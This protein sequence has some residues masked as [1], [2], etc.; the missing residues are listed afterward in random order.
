MRP[1]SL[2]LGGLVGLAG[3]L[4]TP[5]PWPTEPALSLAVGTF[6]VVLAW[7]AVEQV[8]DALDR[9]VE[10]RAH[11]LVGGFGVLPA[12]AVLAPVLGGRT[13][14]EATAI[15]ALV[16]AAAAVITVVAG[17]AHYG[18]LLLRREQIDARITA[19]ESRWRMVVLRVAASIAPLYVLSLAV[20]DVFSTGSAVG[21]LL[22]ILIGTALTG[23]DEYELV[24]LDDHLLFRQG[25]SRGAAA[26]PWRRLRSVTVD[27]D[28]LRVVR[29][30]PYPTVYVA[31]LSGVE[32]R[33]AVLEAFRSYPALH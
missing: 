32:D 8:P 15:R 12:V 26:V 18:A 14:D 27:G 3:F 1:F 13:P 21:S 25:D 17:T 22:G 2:S 31:D 19:V 16:F 28:T 23:T 29:G 24:A 20:G 9:A 4:T 11:W 30:L 5:R 6:V 7:A 33:Q 10:A